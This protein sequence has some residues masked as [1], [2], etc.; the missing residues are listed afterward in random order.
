[1][2]SSLRTPSRLKSPARYAPLIAPT[3]EPTTSTKAVL[4]TDAPL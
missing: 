2:A 4:M 3:D 1:M